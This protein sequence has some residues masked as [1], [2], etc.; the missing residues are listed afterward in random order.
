ML[1]ELAAFVY[2]GQYYV[3]Y[4]RRVAYFIAVLALLEKCVQPLPKL[5]RL[6]L[7]LAVAAVLVWLVASQL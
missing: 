1:V 6:L 7:L 3:L 5:R 4:L 2:A